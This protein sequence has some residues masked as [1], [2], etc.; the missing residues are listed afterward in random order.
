MDIKWNYTKDGLPEA[1]SGSILLLALQPMPGRRVV[2]Y[3]IGFYV[4]SGEQDGHFIF[5]DGHTVWGR[6]LAWAEI[7]FPKE[8]DFSDNSCEVV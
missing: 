7:N 2:Q 1:D 4:G 3:D 8:G 5:Q 6:T